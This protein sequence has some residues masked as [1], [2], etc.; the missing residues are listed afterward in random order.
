MTL[1]E[2][3]PCQDLSAWT[4]EELD[5]YYYP[6]ADEPGTAAQPVPWHRSTRV[7]AGVI[8]TASLAGVVATALL[9]A[10]ETQAPATPRQS[11]AVARITATPLQPVPPP[12]R[13]GPAGPPA[14]AEAPARQQPEAEGEADPDPEA[15][16]EADPEAEATPE[17]LAF[18]PAPPPAV[19]PPGPGVDAEDAQGPRINITRSPMSF[20]P[21]ARG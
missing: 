8:S 7:L 3:L 17:A 13:G 10:L 15:E 1:H 14:I 12:Q 19:P 4:I 11:E 16:A 2:D 9:L 21:A 5:R 6:E 18:D 20:A